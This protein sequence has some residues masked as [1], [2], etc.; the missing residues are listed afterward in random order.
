MGAK[1][2]CADNIV[3]ESYHSLL[4][5][6]TIHNHILYGQIN[7]SVENAANLL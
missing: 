2:T 4:K 1:K 6:G 7:L 5:K 3:I